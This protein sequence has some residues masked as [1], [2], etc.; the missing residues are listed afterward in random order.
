M[1]VTV[2][3][4]KKCQAGVAAAF[5]LAMPRA[6]R[7]Q[8]GDSVHDRGSRPLARVVHGAPRRWGE[9]G[10]F[11]D[12]DGDARRHAMGRPLVHP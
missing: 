6:W 11:R 8:P 9:S 7:L 3:T 12:G 1:Y 2:A 5:A 10:A 4:D